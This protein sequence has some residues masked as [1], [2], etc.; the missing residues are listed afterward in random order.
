MRARSLT[1]KL[2][3]GRIGERDTMAMIDW[4]SL[5]TEDLRALDRQ[6]E[7]AIAVLPLAAVE[8][9][10][11]H[12][13]LGTDAMICDAILEATA[14]RLG[15]GPRVFR[16]PTQ[17]IG[18]SPEHESFVGT[19][20][21]EPEMALASWVAIGA[22][23]ARSGIRKLVVFNSHG[24]QPGV[25]DQMAVRLRRSHGMLV[26]RA[27][28]F[29]LGLP[30]ATISEAEARHG[31]HGGLVETSMM[32]VIRPDLVRMDLARNFKSRDVDIVAR[33]ERLSAEGPGIGIGWLAEDLNPAGVTGDA[34]S[35]T[36][37]LGEKLLDH[38]GASLAALIRDVAALEWPITG[39][40]AGE[41]S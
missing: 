36:I 22:A 29:G 11:P 35:A 23:V 8:Q 40:I 13:P 17:R 7:D 21:I 9:H 38:H 28:I 3:S 26:T 1:V 16:L 15:D 5:T 10:G 14:A 41:T 30:E 34:A 24:G 19:L 33:S 37:E 39:T 6:S 2:V 31:L 32:L 27:N 12:L 25:V 4:E 18:V 20:S